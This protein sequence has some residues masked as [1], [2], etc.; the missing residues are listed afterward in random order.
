MTKKEILEMTGLSEQEFYQQYPTQESWT[1]SYK[2]GGWI[3]KATASIKRRGTEEGITP[4][5]GEID[6]H[7]N[8]KNEKNSPKITPQGF[9]TQDP[10]GLIIG[11]VG[12]NYKANDNLNIS[13]YA[14][15]V[16]NEYFQKFP[17]D[18]GVG[19]NYS[20][21]RF[22]PSVRIGKNPSIGMSYKFNNGGK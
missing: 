9:L 4:K 19:L 17:V 16:G 12:V 15:G 5:R 14:I 11:G 2:K 6:L 18:Y 20:M 1:E 22:N 13:P 10:M 21:G 7:L 3:Q 8:K